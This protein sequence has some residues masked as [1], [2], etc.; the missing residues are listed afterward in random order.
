MVPARLHKAIAAGSITCFITRCA[1]CV[2]SNWAL[3]SCPEQKA[4]SK[5]QV[6]NHARDRTNH[7]D[8]LESAMEG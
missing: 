1:E 4:E 3:T 8:D 5:A 2:V 6:T 7:P